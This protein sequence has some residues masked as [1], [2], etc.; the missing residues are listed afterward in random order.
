MCIERKDVQICY[1]NYLKKTF[2][3]TKPND[4]IAY[5]NSNEFIN[6]AMISRALK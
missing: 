5:F 1:M 4:Y 3:Q 2:S 6:R